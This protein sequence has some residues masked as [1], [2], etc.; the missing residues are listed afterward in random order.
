MNVFVNCLKCL[1]Q[2]QADILG[3]CLREEE[4]GEGERRK[5]E[6]GERGREGEVGTGKHREKREGSTGRRERD[7][8]R[9]GEGGGGR[10]GGNE[11]SKHL[12]YIAKS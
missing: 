9:E 1:G 6:R 4:R 11:L 3:L 12:S 2:S 8:G 10:E 5:R 7:E